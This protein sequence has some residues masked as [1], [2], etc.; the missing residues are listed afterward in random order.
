MLRRLVEERSD[1]TGPRLGVTDRVAAGQHDTGDHPVGH[2]A[3][4]RRRPDDALVAPQGEVAQRVPAAPPLEQCAHL[5][6]VGVGH[7]GH[8]LRRPQQQIDDGDGRQSAERDIDVAEQ[9]TPPPDQMDRAAET[10]QATD[11]RLENRAEVPVTDHAAAEAAV[12]QVPT[13]GNR[14]QQGAECQIDDEQA[15]PHGERPP[16]GARIP[17]GLELPAGDDKPDEYDGAGHRLLDVEAFD[18]VEHDADREQADDPSEGTGL[19]APQPA[20]QHQQQQPGDGCDRGRGGGERDRHDGRERPQPP[21]L[22]TGQGT[23]EVDDA[24]EGDDE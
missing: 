8:R 2:A 16:P 3:L 10:D 20:G 6:F 4:A 15:E 19:P 12:L 24:G 1:G 11:D 14:Q 23:H 17:A 5:V 21:A 13:R 9:V 7:L 22:G 18:D